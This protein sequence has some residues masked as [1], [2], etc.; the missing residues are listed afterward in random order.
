M[1]LEAVK[2]DESIYG[3]SLKNF[4]SMELLFLPS[5]LAKFSKIYYGSSSEINPRMDAFKKR[6]KYLLK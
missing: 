6:L 4:Q 5:D 1:Y 3:E 2:E